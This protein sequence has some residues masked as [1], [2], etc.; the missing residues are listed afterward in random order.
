MNAKRPP[1]RPLPFDAVA[2]RRGI[3][4]LAAS[5]AQWAEFLERHPP[6]PLPDD[7][8]ASGWRTAANRHVVEVVRWA[9]SV[10]DY[11]A[12]CG[13]DMEAAP[14]YKDAR[15]DVAIKRLL[16]GLRYAA[17]KSLHLLVDLASS[18]PPVD[19]VVQS[20]FGVGQLPPRDPRL[21]RPIYRWPD[22][23]HLLARSKP[24]LVLQTAYTDHLADKF[25]YLA[26]DHA[27]TWLS[28]QR[29]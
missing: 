14:G 3:D 20:H 8:V 25:V 18:P 23:A 6:I 1:L 26:L 17:N 29:P 22:L 10:D 7:A 12:G 13:T 5:H 28:A 9:R 19:V 16:D 15:D 21:D 2:A 24:D 4:N 27:V 11:L